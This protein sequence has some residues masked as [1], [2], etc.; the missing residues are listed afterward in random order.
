MLVIE[1]LI[2]TWEPESMTLLQHGYDLQLNQNNCYKDSCCHGHCH[3][4]QQLF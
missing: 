4:H 1:V 3:C 2:G